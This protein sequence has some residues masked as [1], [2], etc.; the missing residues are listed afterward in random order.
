[1]GKNYYLPNGDDANELQ[2][3]KLTVQNTKHPKL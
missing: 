1:M 2:I 3:N